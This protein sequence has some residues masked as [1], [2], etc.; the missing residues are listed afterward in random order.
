MS[1]SLTN[2]WTR[3]A[4]LILKY[5]KEQNDAGN[6][7]PVF[8]T[9]LGFQLLSY[10]TSGYNSSILT[11]VNGDEAIIHPLFLLNDGYLFSTFTSAQRA[12][13]TQ[14][15]GLMYFNHLWAVS[16]DTYNTNVNL[17]NFWNLI[18]TATSPRNERFVAYFEAKKYPFYGVQ[19]HPEKN[20]FEWKVYADRSIEGVEV[21]QIMS[22]RFV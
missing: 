2:Q 6:P 21:V 14:G 3:N 1:F 10:L 11:R 5:A 22:N 4:D 8:G 16:T 9:C 20:P 18:A 15:A 12:K 19:F 17:K 13:L 7:F